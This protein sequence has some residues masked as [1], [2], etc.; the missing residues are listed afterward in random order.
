MTY[1]EFVLAIAYECQN[2]PRRGLDDKDVQKRILDFAKQLN[3][4]ELDV[5]LYLLKKFVKIKWNEYELE[6]RNALDFAQN[7]ELKNKKIY[8]SP[9]Q[10]K[11]GSSAPY[12]LRFLAMS[13]HL[14]KH[15]N[16]EGSDMNFCSE[17]VQLPRR[18]SGNPKARLLLIDDYIGSGYTAFER[19]CDIQKKV[20]VTADQI[21]LLSIAGAKKGID[22]LNFFYKV[23]CPF[24]QDKGISSI[25][26]EFQKDVF[27]NS[28]I[29]I[30]QKFDLGQAFGY[31]ACEGTISLMNTPNNT[32]QMFHD[33]KRIKNPPFPRIKL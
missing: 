13:P 4:S 20:N 8:I 6:L 30:A 23:I 26:N 16:L 17:D 29:S 24:V 28:I 18:I 5:Y 19:V 33:E 7:G 9:M 14:K 15:A 11:P 27:S 12:L 32:F 31:G 1:E 21:I 3:S 25:P 2:D 22:F 10:T